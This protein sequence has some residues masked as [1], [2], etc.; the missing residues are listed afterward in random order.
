MD[1]LVRECGALG[2]VLL[3]VLG[4][5]DFVSV[6]SL[7]AVSS[8][9]R[10]YITTSA[11]PF[12]HSLLLSHFGPTK[13][14]KTWRYTFHCR[15]WLPPA[16]TKIRTISSR[17]RT[18]HAP[19]S[20]PKTK[21]HIHLHPLLIGNSTTRYF[22]HQGYAKHRLSLLGARFVFEERYLDTAD[23]KAFTY[24]KETIRH[25]HATFTLSELYHR[26]ALR[27]FHVQP[28]LMPF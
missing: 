5:L 27:P 23:R 14:V 6:C 18:Q 10:E 13:R 1:W 8:Y 28:A 20:R 11:E 21:E 16:E 17:P 4:E 12:W 7:C 9:F 3:L 26:S 25:T 22:C 15:Y 2:D 24:D 19:P